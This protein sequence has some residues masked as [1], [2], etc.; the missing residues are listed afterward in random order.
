MPETL[1]DGDR[2]YPG[3]RYPEQ[4]RIGQFNWLKIAGFSVIPEDLLVT[5]RYFGLRHTDTAL[6]AFLHGPDGSFYGVDHNVGSY[7]GERTIWD[8]PAGGLIAGG[9]GAL[10]AAAGGM[11]PDPRHG[12]WSGTVAQELTSDGRVVFRGSGVAGAEEV[13]IGTDDVEWS[14][15][16]GVVQLAGNLVGQ[17]CQWHHSWRRPDGSTGEM[18]WCRHGYDVEGSYLGESV[19]GQVIVNS[20]WGNEPY[21]DTWWVRHR[22]GHW[23]SF[24]NVY[25]DGTSEYGQILVQEYGA[26]GAVVVD[27][28][29]RQV[30]C[31]QNVNAIVGENGAMRYEFGDGQVWEYAAD[32][33][34]YTHYNFNDNDTWVTWAGAIHRVGDTRKV[35]RGNATYQTATRL[36]EPLPFT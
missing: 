2:G 34:T 26:R 22:V 32:Q 15:T 27:D 10:Q 9:I 18:L 36:P 4:R 3:G 12:A 6:D 14:S 8:Q 28:S 20:M 35:V 19:H 11:V 33:R 23:A 7:G 24:G 21:P 29:G 1:D 25:D 13:S 17:G 16:G 30:V 31:T 5:R